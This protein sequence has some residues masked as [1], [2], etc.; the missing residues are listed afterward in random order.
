MR[1]RSSSSRHRRSRSREAEDPSGGEAHP[2]MNLI[3]LADDSPHAQRMG[4]RILRDEGFSV[5]CV[6]DGESALAHLAGE[7]PDLVIADA[8][9]PG[10][11]GFALCRLVKQYRPHVRFVLTAG[12]LEDLNEDEARDAGCDGVLRK[13]FEASVAAQMI[14]PLIERAQ[15]TRGDHSPQAIPVSDAPVAAASAAPNPERVRIA[16]ESALQ[17]AVPRLV[18]DITEKVLIALGH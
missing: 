17:E 2:P 5:T 3:L 11:S 13:P 14:R 7:D 1:V 15:K 4:E 9:L 12:L 8:F 18:H 6:A 16:V 10:H